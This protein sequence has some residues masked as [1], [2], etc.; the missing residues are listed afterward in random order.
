M[1]DVN[2]G[3]SRFPHDGG[4]E[5]APRAGQSA[6]GSTGGRHRR[7]LDA[8]EAQ[9]SNQPEYTDYDDAKL[10]D[11]YE[12]DAEPRAIPKRGLAMVLIAVAVL[13][14]LWGL[15]SLT[16]GDKDVTNTADNPSPT[17]EAQPAPG[18]QP[19]GDAPASQPGDNPSG[20]PSENRAPGEGRDGEASESGR[21]PIAPG[22]TMTAE[23]ET[24]NVY[25]NSTV[26]GLAADV[27]DT[28]RGQGT[29]VG[30]V[31]NLP[32]EVLEQNTVFFDPNTPGAEERARVLAD[33]VG[34][35]ARANIDSLPAGA[36]NPGSITLVVVEPVQ[37]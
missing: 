36:R 37:L 10:E 3:S 34:G 22:E 9:A 23:N 20:N 4:L 16:Q 8:E 1:T 13:L 25:N 2:S 28:L 33:R 11:V 21:A 30:E 6:A 17:Q 27:S 35:V 24:I 7:R 15:Y 29:N 5:D 31:G 18:T 14:G 12:D 19:T 26:S 32:N